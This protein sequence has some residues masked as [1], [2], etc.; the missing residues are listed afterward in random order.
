MTSKARPCTRCRQEDARVYMESGARCLP[1][2]RQYLQRTFR[3][4][5]GRANAS[6]PT[7]RLAV[8]LSGDFSSAACVHLAHHYVHSLRRAPGLQ[9]PPIIAIHVRCGELEE[10]VAQLCVAQLSNTTL[11]IVSRQDEALIN[12]VRDPSDRTVLTRAAVLSTLKTTATQ[13]NAT[14]LLL[15][16][17]ATRKA[18]HLVEAVACGRVLSSSPAHH[19]E[20]LVDVRTRILVRY[21]RDAFHSLHFAPHA[22]HGAP[23]PAIVDRFMADAEADNPAS[24]HNVVRT[25]ARLQDHT[26]APCPLCDTPM[27]QVSS[28][29]DNSPCG[30]SCVIRQ[31]LVCNGCSGML[32]RSQAVALDPVAALL[33]SRSNS[34]LQ[35]R[36]RLMRAEIDQ[37]L[38]DD[39]EDVVKCDRL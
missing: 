24:V 31:P 19:V 5:L 20:P 32:R 29:C 28:D 8:A 39:S 3:V 1:C 9:P 22:P 25:A 21:A 11:H 13:L 15:G 2:V 33:H 18:A 27:M 37:F 36:R 34:A 4:A 6:G 17:S 23:I 38:L 30:T 14:A 7:A 26:G 10:K 16:T 35:Q 12:N